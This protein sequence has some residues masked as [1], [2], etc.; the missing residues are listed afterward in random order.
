M[1]TKAGKSHLRPLSSCSLAVSVRHNVSVLCA[2]DAET[3]PF[4]SLPA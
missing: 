4:K 1:G 2:A 3:N